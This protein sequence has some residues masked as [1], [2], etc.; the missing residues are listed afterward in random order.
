[1]YKQMGHTDLIADNT[2]HYVDIAVRLM[3]DIEY[4][5]M[6]SN[7]ILER[8]HKKLHMNKLVADEWLGFLRKVTM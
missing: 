6:Q 8:F 3:V 4:R 1:M 2:T 5:Q 7:M